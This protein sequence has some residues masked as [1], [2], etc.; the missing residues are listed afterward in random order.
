MLRS[1]SARGLESVGQVTREELGEDREAYVGREEVF[2]Y[3]I[4]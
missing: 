2:E 1:G 3:G 4:Q